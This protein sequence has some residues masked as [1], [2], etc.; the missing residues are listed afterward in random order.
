MVSCAVCSHRNATEARMKPLTTHEEFC[1]KN[2]SHFVVARGRIPT[3]RTRDQFATL[4]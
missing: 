1:L 3:T 2:A 4:P